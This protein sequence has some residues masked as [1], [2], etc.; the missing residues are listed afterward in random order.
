M[1]N[2]SVIKLCQVKTEK[3]IFS[4]EDR[5]GECVCFR[6]GESRYALSI[7]ELSELASSMELEIEK[8]IGIDS[9]LINHFPKDVLLNLANN[10]LLSEIENVKEKFVNQ[11]VSSGLW[12]NNAGRITN[13]HIIVISEK[14]KL[15]I[16]CKQIDSYRNLPNED[17][18]SS[19]LSVYFTKKGERRLI[20]KSFEIR[21]Q[22]WLSNIIKAIVYLEQRVECNFMNKMD[23][24][25]RLWLRN[26][27]KQRK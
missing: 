11:E 14:S 6:V 5:L 17:G 18:K 26:K 12:S 10:N 25:Y 19:I 23:Q 8:M 16:G 22:C 15:K 21:L 13:N 1:P 3:G 27:Y 4:V 2:P 9:H 7:K 20:L 24:H